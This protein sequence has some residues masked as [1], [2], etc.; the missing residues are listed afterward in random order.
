ML[1][2][3]PPEVGMTNCLARA[4]SLDCMSRI[5]APNEDLSRSKYFKVQLS[6]SNPK[7]IG[8]TQIGIR[9]L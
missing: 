3:L 8:V 9:L 4:Y 6:Y 2:D 5:K 1:L 7:S